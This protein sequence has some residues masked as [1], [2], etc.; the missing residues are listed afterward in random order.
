MNL[1]EV[2]PNTYENAVED[3]SGVVYSTDADAVLCIYVSGYYTAKELE[4]RLRQLA[5]ATRLRA[6]SKRM[7]LT[8]QEFCN[9][10]TAILVNKPPL[11]GLVCGTG[12][13]VLDDAN[14]L[15]A[16]PRKGDETYATLF[17]A[18]EVDMNAW[19]DETG[20]WSCM[21]AAQC[22]DALENP[23]F[24]TIEVGCPE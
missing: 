8:Y 21:T 16:A 4:M 2:A 6:E 5:E 22:T 14:N 11:T 19:N 20:A 24:T 10:A 12:A 17:D 9:A 13:I 15:L 3:Q 23:V 1:I 7:A 18:L